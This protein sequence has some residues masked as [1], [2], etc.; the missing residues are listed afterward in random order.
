MAW[1]VAYSDLKGRIL[2]L[3]DVVNSP[4]HTSVNSPL[5]TF[6]NGSISRLYDEIT[7]KVQDFSLTEIPLS[8]PKGNST[9]GLPSDFYK[10]RDIYVTDGNLSFKIHP[11][12][13]QQEAYINSIAVLNPMGAPFRYRLQ[14]SN[15]LF[16]PVPED[17]YSGVLK[18]VPTAPLFIGPASAVD[19]VNGWDTFVLWDVAAMVLDIE[20][21][22]SGVFHQR[23]EQELQRAVRAASTRNHADPEPIMYFPDDVTYSS[24]GRY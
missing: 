1:S 22:E 17:T 9:V 6:V 10:L 7:A 24:R 12:S 19:F 11:F 4:R 16:S 15:L 3:A 20:G 5:M 18:Y 14:G 21:R 8:V 13:L 2:V 23:A